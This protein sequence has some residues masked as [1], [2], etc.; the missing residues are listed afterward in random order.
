MWY[1]L[2]IAMLL[3]FC[4]S[5]PPSQTYE[6]TLEVKSVFKNGERIPVKYT[7]EGENISPP[8]KILNVKSGVKSFVII[9]EDPDA[10]SGT[11]VHW[12]AWNITSTKIP[13]GIPKL[14]KVDE[15]IRMNQGRNDFNKIG[16]DGPCPPPGKPHR[17]YFKVY[18]LD[19][20]LK[21]NYNKY[22]ILEA[23]KGHVI[24]YGELYGLYGR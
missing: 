14:K 9:C 23:I 10:P 7:C 22:N 16:Y 5:Q 4:I 21:G 3:M 17:Y 1:L 19:T 24:Q 2:V 8:L 18:A 12:I 6:K 13:E 11:F 20:F 15:P